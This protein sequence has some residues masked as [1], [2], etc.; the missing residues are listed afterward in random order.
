MNLKYQEEWVKFLKEEGNLN[1]N[2]CPLL[3]NQKLGN[4]SKKI[5]Y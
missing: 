1:K 2:Q 4:N 5:L 3:K